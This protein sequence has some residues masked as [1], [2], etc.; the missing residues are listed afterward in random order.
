MSR[1]PYRTGSGTSLPGTPS[2]PSHVRGGCNPQWMLFNDF[3][4]TVSSPSEVLQLFGGSKIPC[5]LYY[6]RV[7][8]SDVASLLCEPDFRPSCFNVPSS[9]SAG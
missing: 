3:C 6:T 7:G 5:L 9:C 1:G 2:T 4:V 8:H